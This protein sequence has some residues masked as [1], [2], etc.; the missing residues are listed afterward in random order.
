MPRVLYIWI[1]FCNKKL[2]ISGSAIKVHTCTG[3]LM[4][5]ILSMER[6]RN[7]NFFSLEITGYILSGATAL[8]S[9][10]IQL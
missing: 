1:T 4:S 3:E 8:F 2:L 7:S 10:D 6:A 9:L 5:H